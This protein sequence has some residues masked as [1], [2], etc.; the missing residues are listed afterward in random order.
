MSR[1]DAAILAHLNAR[2]APYVVIGGWAVITHGNVRFTLDIDVLIPE[3]EA[4]VL[5]SPLRSPR[6]GP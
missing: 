6:S 4:S 5:E 1:D 2:E 3:D